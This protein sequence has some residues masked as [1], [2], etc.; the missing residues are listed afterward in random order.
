MLRRFLQRSSAAALLA[1]ALISAPSARAIEFNF[2]PFGYDVE[3]TIPTPGAVWDSN[4]GVVTVQPG[5]SF[6]D[7]V[8]SINGYDGPQFGPFYDEFEQPV[9]IDVTL[10]VEFSTPF[11]G[12]AVDN[13]SLGPIGPA[14][15]GET[16]FP[17]QYFASMEVDSMTLQSLQKGQITLFNVIAVDPAAGSLFTVRFSVDP[18]IDTSA[19]PVDTTVSVF[20]IVPEPSLMRVASLTTVPGF[21][22]TV[23]VVP[24]PSTWALMLGGFGLIGFAA[25][26]RM[27]AH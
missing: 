24:E 8:M 11:I 23:R 26:R 2:D 21:Q 7:V 3:A 14:L 16:G 10:G 1:T 15:I 20:A 4:T 17:P 22:I 19:G 6:F 13:G 27:Q 25:R 18:S 9:A 5:V 12:L